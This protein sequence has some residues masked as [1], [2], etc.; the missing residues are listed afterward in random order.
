MLLELWPLLKLLPPQ[1]P[2][3]AWSVVTYTMAQ[4]SDLQAKLLHSYLATVKSIKRGVQPPPSSLILTPS[5]PYLSLI[6]PLSFLCLLLSSLLFS[7]PLSLFL[8]SLLS[9]SLSLCLSVSLCLS[10]P[11]SLSPSLCVSLY[12]SLC[13]YV[14][15]SVSVCL[16]VCLSL[17]LSLSLSVSL[18]LS[19]SHL[20]FPEF[21]IF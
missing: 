11:L 12:L 14:C 16:Y 5:S 6:S 7:F 10:I 1:P 17:S 19:L 2:Q 18:S 13:L 8:S 9:L 21:S 3:E 15:L 4:A 20:I